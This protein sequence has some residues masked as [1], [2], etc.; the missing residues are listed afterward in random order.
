MW[1][2]WRSIIRFLLMLLQLFEMFIFAKDSWKVRR[3]ICLGRNSKKSLLSCFCGNRYLKLFVND[4]C[5]HLFGNVTQTINFSFTTRGLLRYL[6]YLWCQTQRVRG[7]KQS[8]MSPRCWTVM[9]YWIEKPQC[10]GTQLE[11]NLKVITRTNKLNSVY[12]QS[13]VNICILILTTWN[14]IG[15][16]LE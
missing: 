7:I 16:I 4:L 2:S 14:W 12:T 15:E 10:A 6:D 9:Y 13:I 5:G 3:V 1:F 11:I 8:I